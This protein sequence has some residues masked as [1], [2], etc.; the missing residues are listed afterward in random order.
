MDYD[1]TPLLNR[2]AALGAGLSDSCF[3]ALAEGTITR[4]RLSRVRN[5]FESL[6]HSE[7]V[8]LEALIGEM[9]ELQRRCRPVPVNWS[10]V[11]AVV[12]LLRNLRKQRCAPPSPLAP[13][14]IELLKQFLSCPDV[15]ELALQYG[16][17]RAEL[18]DRVE[19]LLDRS[20]RLAEAAGDP[21]IGE[22]R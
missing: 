18:L 6:N 1:A 2:V 12:V 17:T 8:R 11:R 15:G 19:G 22:L 3:V 7:F 9:E 21:K 13:S 4:T 16:A 5:N 14:E 10:D 20:K